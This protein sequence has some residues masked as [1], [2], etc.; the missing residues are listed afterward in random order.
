VAYAW[1]RKGEWHN[2]YYLDDKTVTGISP[3]LT[4]P[5]KAL[6]NPN[7]L[8]ANQG[9]SFQGSIVLD[10]GFVLTPEEAQALIEKDPRNNDLLFPY[11]NGQD[12]NSNF[13]QSPSR[14]VIN[15]HDWALDAEH[16]DPKKPKGHPYAADYPDCLKIVEEKVKDERQS[17]PP[18][19]S[20]N[21]S[22]AERWWQFGAERVGLYKAIAGCDRVLV[23][24]RVSNTNSIAFVP[25]GLV[26][27][28]MIVVFNFDDYASFALLQTMAHT[29]WLTH[30]SSTLGA[31]TRY[32]PTDCF[33]TFPFPESTNNLETIGETYYN[34]RQAIMQTRQE[35]LTKTYNRFHD[36]AE[37]SEDIKKLRLP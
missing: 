22:V 7:R 21:K 27:S 18:K 29:E 35:G 23:R 14:W 32:T 31:G 5:G 37:T 2:E 19:N 8:A 24:A 20:W 26:M 1:L 33:E 15:F 16:D 36:L 4:I 11:L 28:E 12:L 10:M 25:K 3:Y 6:G 30:N 13:D 34:H 17:L 9:K